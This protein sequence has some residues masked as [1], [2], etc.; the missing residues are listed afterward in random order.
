[1]SPFALLALSLFLVA[2]TGCKQKGGTD[3]KTESSTASGKEDSGEAAAVKI[4]VIVPLT[5]S[6]ASTGSEM[7]NAVEMA[8]EEFNNG[9]DGKDLKVE[10]VKRDDKGDATAGVV[11]A[12][13]VT[14]DD[15]VMGVVAHLNSGVFLPASASY[16]E[17]GLVAI[18]PATTNPEITKQGLAE[19]FR[20]CTTDTVQGIAAARY[21]QEELKATKVSIL[22]DKTQYGEGLA[23]QLKKSL[24]ERGITV[25]GYAGI[26]PG[27]SDYR[28]PLTG[29]VQTQQPDVLYFGGLYTEGGKLVQDYR[30]LGGKGV[31]MG[32]DGILGDVTVKVG[33]EA[34]EGL[35]A[36]MPGEPADQLASAKDFLAAYE[37]RFGSPIQNYGP[38]SYDVANI[39]LNAIKE[40]K[41]KGE[42]T[43][44]A[45]LAAVKA[46]KFDGVLGHTEFDENGDTSN[47][48]ITFYQVEGG[49]FKP[50]KT[51]QP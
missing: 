48:N 37:K 2:G 29:I 40:A 47:K 19:I 42:I 43:R 36:S 31:F 25:T 27:E 21:I 5:G 16:H 34:A 26:T 24:E 44:E 3:S 18:S 9:P 50:K 23:E 11:A 39:L 49:K 45:V 13:S 8:V 17:G 33:G 41:S 20:V 1:M 51:L 32:G 6:N 12:K 30:G 38:Y 46:T 28:G 7:A 4:A 14:Q 22:H 10:L 15:E 35:I